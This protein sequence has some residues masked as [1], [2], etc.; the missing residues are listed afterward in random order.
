MLLIWLGRKE[1]R[2]KG[3]REGK[4]KGRRRERGRKGKGRRKGKCP[5]PRFGGVG[6]DTIG[7]GPSV[8]GPGTYFF[9]IIIQTDVL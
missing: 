9:F 1:A 4:K 8:P 2:K 5:F 3:K 7:G 6:G